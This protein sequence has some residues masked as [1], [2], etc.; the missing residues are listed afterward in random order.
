MIPTKY[1]RQ[2]K[3]KIR[4]CFPDPKTR[5]F[6]FGSSIREDTFRDI[7]VGLEGNIDEQKLS[8]L[9]EELE[10][11]NFPFLVDLVDFTY[12]DKGFKDFVLSKETK[13][14]I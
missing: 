5:I 9:R 7:D 8:K 13:R 2:L 3:T 6:I 1:L 10:N 14:W 4:H 11:S 12:V